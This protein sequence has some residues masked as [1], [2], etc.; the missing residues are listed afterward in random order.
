M[1][2]PVIVTASEG[3]IDLVREGET[4]LYVPPGDPGA[5]RAAIER[6][7]DDPALAREM[8]RKGRAFAEA[9]LSLDD[10]VARVAALVDA[11]D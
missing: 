9:H 2:R 7:L 4:G 6:L 8:G 3:Q 10:Y 11:H 5:L 1:G